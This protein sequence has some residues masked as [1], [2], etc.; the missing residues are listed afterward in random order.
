MRNV[1]SANLYDKQHFR[2]PP[3]RGPTFPKAGNGGF[4]STWMWRPGASLPGLHLHAES[5][6][7]NCVCGTHTQ[8]CLRDW[9]HALRI[10]KEWER[11][12]GGGLPE[13]HLNLESRNTVGLTAPTL[14]GLTLFH[15]T[16]SHPQ[17]LASGRLLTPTE[18]SM[19]GGGRP[20]LPSP[21]YGQSCSCKGPRYTSDPRPWG[22]ERDI[23]TG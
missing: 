10:L 19:N 14:K 7:G 17:H 18:S 20:G 9:P 5:N 8:H 12:W 11:P 3:P 4:L 6:T 21:R 23:S 15:P 22:W 13:S 2:S 16:N 1:D